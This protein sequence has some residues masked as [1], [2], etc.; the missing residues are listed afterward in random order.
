MRTEQII[1]LAL[2]RKVGK[3]LV[4]DCEDSGAESIVEAGD[5]SDKEDLTTNPSRTSSS[6]RNG[7]NNKRRLQ[8]R[9]NMENFV[10]K[11]LEDAGRGGEF[12]PWED[13]SPLR[14]ATWGS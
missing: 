13:R 10:K 11:K 5:A 6:R 2:A 14:L 1:A 3:K 7:G 12:I 9:A 8:K 4:E